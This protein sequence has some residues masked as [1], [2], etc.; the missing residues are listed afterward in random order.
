M[1]FACSQASASIL[2][3]LTCPEPNG[4]GRT[5][6][7]QCF[8][9]SVFDH[10]QHIPSFLCHLTIVPSVMVGESDG[11]STGVEPEINNSHKSA[12]WS[13]L[14]NFGWGA[15]IMSRTDSIFILLRYA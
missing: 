8:Y 3:L 4:T 13:T 2:K 6:W 9:R 5:H 10:L 7:A 14:N 11:I 12:L 1:V 15:V